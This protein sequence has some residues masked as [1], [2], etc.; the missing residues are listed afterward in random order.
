VSTRFVAAGHGLT[1]LD[2]VRLAK[3]PFLTEV[4]YI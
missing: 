2:W 4:I 3:M 1:H